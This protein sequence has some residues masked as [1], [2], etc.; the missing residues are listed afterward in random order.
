MEASLLD[1]AVVYAACETASRIINDMPEVAV[2]WLQDG[3]RKVSP[4]I[5][6]R[7]SHRLEDLFDAFWDDRDFLLIDEFQDVA[8]DRA[9]F[10]KDKLNLPEEAFEPMYAALER[11][12]IPK[13]GCE[14]GRSDDRRRDPGALPLLE[15]AVRKPP[16]VVEV[17]NPEIPHQLLTGI[18]HRYHDLLVGPCDLDVAQTEADCRLVEVAWV[19]EGSDF[20]CTYEE[21]VEHLRNDV[22]R[23]AQESAVPRPTSTVQP[24]NDPFLAGKIERAR[25]TSLEDGTQIEAR[26]EG[27]VVVDGF[28]SYL[29]DPEDAAWVADDDDEDMPPAVFPTAVGRLGSGGQGRGN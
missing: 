4:R 1:A 7:A 23:A 27:W 16:R 28:Y 3:P 18:D 14:L 19:M 20:D 9:R 17:E 5:I 29:V 24:S 15:A 2:A 26:G 21:W 6:K 8:P 22:L 11:W 10:L 13:C 25:T 12:N